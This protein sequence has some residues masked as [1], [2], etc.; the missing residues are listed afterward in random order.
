MLPSLAL[1]VGVRYD[2]QSLTD[3]TG[4][5]ARGSASHGSADGSGK[6]V[7]RGA[8]GIYYSQIRDEH[9]G[10]VGAQRPDR[11]LH[12]QR[13]AR[14]A[15]VPDRP[16][17]ASGVPAR[18]D[19]AA[20]R[21]HD[22]PR[23]GRLL[24]PVLRRLQAARLS[25]RPRESPDSAGLSRDRARDRVTALSCLS[26]DFSRGR[27]G[28]TRN[29]D[30]NA[31]DAFVRTASGQTR[32]GTAADATRPITP[33]PNGY[34]RILVTVSQ[35]HANYDG[36]QLNLRTQLRSEGQRAPLLHV[37]AHAQRLGAGRAG[38]RSERR[39]TCWRTSGATASSTSATVSW[40]AAGGRF[41]GISSAA[42]SSSTRRRVPT[43][44]RPA[45]TTT[46]TAPTRDRPVVDG[47]LLG[48][49][50]QR[51]TGY[52]RSRAL[53]AEGRPVLGGFTLSLRAEGFNVTN[54]ANIV[55]RNGTYGNAT[56]GTPLPTFGQALGGISNVDPGRQFQFIVRLS[57]LMSA[58][59]R[60]PGPGASRSDSGRARSWTASASTCVRAR[61]S[62]SSA[63]TAR[64]RRPCSSAWPAFFRR[65]RDA[66]SKGATSPRPMRRD[67]L[68]YVP[69]AIAPWP[70][71]S[72][73][74]GCSASRPPL[75]ARARQIAQWLGA[76]ALGLC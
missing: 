13:G 52:L 28:F 23:A 5:S 29:L 39:R 71:Q 60:P 25:G 58:A 68:F 57:P 37:V 17:P 55:G 20:A 22:P 24:R 62:G 51:G 3:A 53:P 75:R 66:L 27:P 2:R 76:L 6:T 64:A 72:A 19:S 48:R 38:R 4:N 49:N 42:A 70:D 63:P 14:T 50:S 56:D 46:A 12:L 11:N 33:V 40:R 61:S 59:R 69:D 10:D 44:R 30:E 74:A 45:S 54:H 36:L 26:T 8:Y 41:P 15:R 73:A 18:R 16:R 31:P 43:T 21:H 32:S 47:V 7:L 35:G 34:R 1:N 9:V 67:V 65:H